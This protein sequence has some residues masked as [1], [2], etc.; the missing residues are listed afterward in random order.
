M[1][2]WILVLKLA[3]FVISKSLIATVSIHTIYSRLRIAS[4]FSKAPPKN[5]KVFGRAAVSTL[6]EFSRCQPNHHLSRRYL[7]R[8][9]SFGPEMEPQQ[10]QKATPFANDGFSK[11]VKFIGGSF[12]GFVANHKFSSFLFEGAQF[13]NSFSAED[14]LFES[15]EFSACSFGGVFRNSK[16]SSVSISGKAPTLE[17]ETFVDCDLS[18][19]KICAVD[20][21]SFKDCNLQSATFS[22][23]NCRFHDCNLSNATV[24]VLDE[25]TSFEDCNLSNA[26]LSFLYNAQ[27]SV[28][29][30]CGLA[31]AVITLRVAFGES[32]GVSLASWRYT[33]PDESFSV[34]VE[35][36]GQ[37]VDEE[38]LR[39][40][41]PQVVQA[42]GGA[43]VTLV[44][45]HSQ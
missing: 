18:Q 12:D 40:E 45:P 20:K 22:G 8:P 13:A 11:G 4:L 10:S 31:S 38:T 26:K 5:R 44:L 37:G 32:I 36:V 2:A 41:L 1:L 9:L 27:R 24:R 23:E 19:A 14:C 39:K 30:A 15:G 42:L 17:K 25:N 28:V 29:K 35:V 7:S 21:I 43:P 34:V 33:A 3:V 16:L 6:P